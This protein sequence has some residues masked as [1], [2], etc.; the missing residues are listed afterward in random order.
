MLQIVGDPR[1]ST[2]MAEERCFLAIAAGVNQILFDEGCD[3][4][5]G[6]I[7]SASM[8]TQQGEDES[9]CTSRFCAVS[10]AVGLAH[11]GAN[12]SLMNPR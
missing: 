5:L 1:K 2:S 12:R 9:R 6:I 10:L 8:K 11:W 3:A 7:G 4:I